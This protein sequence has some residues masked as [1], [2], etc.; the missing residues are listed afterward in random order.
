MNLKTWC[1]L[2]SWRQKTLAA[3]L[4]KSRSVVSQAVNGTIRVPPSWYRGI[5]EFTK[6]E[7]GFNDLVPG[8]PQ[9]TFTRANGEVVT[10]QRKTAHKGGAA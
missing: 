5:A 2:I 10:D 4:D 1:E 9:K 6:G 7:V 8:T 3:H